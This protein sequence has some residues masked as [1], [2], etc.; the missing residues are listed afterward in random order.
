MS[1]DAQINTYLDNNI[2]DYL[3]LQEIAES[4]LNRQEADVDPNSDVKHL[5]YEDYKANNNSFYNLDGITINE[6]LVNEFKVAI[7]SYPTL[8]IAQQ[9]S[10]TPTDQSLNID[11][12]GGAGKYT[13]IPSEQANYFIQNYNILDYYGNDKSGFSAT[14]FQNKNTGEKIISFRSTEFGEDFIKDTSAD[15]EIGNFGL[16]VGQTISMVQYIEHLKQTGI[17]KTDDNIVATGYSLGSNLSSEFEKMYNSE[18]NIN[19][20]YNFNGPGA[21]SITNPIGMTGDPYINLKNEY[22]LYQNAVNQICNLATDPTNLSMNDANNIITQLNFTDSEKTR[23]TNFV[24]SMYLNKAVFP[25]V[26]ESNMNLVDL[27]NTIN[28]QST[29]NEVSKS[30]LI[31]LNEDGY[32]TIYK[33]NVTTNSYYNNIR[34]YIVQEFSAQKANIGNNSPGLSSGTFSL[35]SINSVLFSGIEGGKT[36]YQIDPS[37]YN[38]KATWIAGRSLQNAEDLMPSDYS[39]VSYS[40]YY[41]NPNDI[42]VEDRPDLEGNGTRLPISDLTKYLT[43]DFGNT[44]SITLLNKSLGLMSFL[45]KIEGA[46]NIDVAKYTSIIG[47]STSEKAAHWITNS[48]LQAGSFTELNYG[49]QNSIA[50]VMNRI[51]KAIVPNSNQPDILFDNTLGGWADVNKLNQLEKRKEEI[52]NTLK[53]QNTTISLVSLYQAQSS[54]FDLNS[55]PKIITSKDDIYTKVMQNDA[56]GQAY[57]YALE[58]LNPFVIKGLD[59]N[60]MPNFI[61]KNPTDESIEWYLNRIDILREIIKDNTNNNP[62][63]LATS[64]ISV[65]DKNQGLK[66]HTVFQEASKLIASNMS[67]L[68]Q[69]TNVPSEVANNNS[70]NYYGLHSSKFYVDG[71]FAYSPSYIIKDKLK[72]YDLDKEQAINNPIKDNLYYLNPLVSS[73]TSKVD[74][75]NE[76]IFMNF[77]KNAIFNALNGNSPAIPYLTNYAGSLTD[78][79]NFDVITKIDLKGGDDYIEIKNND[80]KAFIEGSSGKK[81]YYL[82]AKETV[83]DDKDKT[84]TI[85]LDGIK[86]TGGIYQDILTRV[87]TEVIDGITHTLTYKLDNNNQLTITHDNTG[88]KVIISN[89]SN[90][91]NGS[92]FGFNINEG[93][94]N[95]TVLGVNLESFLNNTIQKD[96]LQTT[97]SSS[98]T[99]ANAFMNDVTKNFSIAGNNAVRY[100]SGTDLVIYDRTNPTKMSVV[101][102]FYNAD[103]TI[104]TY[105]STVTRVVNADTGETAQDPVSSQINIV[106]ADEHVQDIPKTTVYHIDQLLF[107]LRNNMEIDYRGNEKY[108]LENPT[109]DNININKDGNDLVFT[110]N[111]PT[112][113]FNNGVYAEGKVT[114]KNYF[115]FDHSNSTNMLMYQNGVRT[116]LTPTDVN[117]KLSLR[118]SDGGVNY[119]ANATDPFHIIVGGMGDDNIKGT[120]RDEVFESLGGN[121]YN[122][123]SIQSSNDGNDVFTG[124]G[125]NDTFIFSGAFGS[126]R[127]TDFNSGDKIILFNSINGIPVNYQAIRSGDDL[128]LKSTNT[129]GVYNTQLKVDNYFVN[130]DY[131]NNSG[132][133]MKDPNLIYGTDS[134]GEVV[135]ATQSQQDYV[136]QTADLQKIDTLT[137]NNS[138]L[139]YSQTDPTVE[140]TPVDPSDPTKPRDSYH[141]PGTYHHI[142]G[143]ELDNTITITRNNT[144]VEGGEVKSLLN[145][146]NDTYI[147]NI[148]EN[149]PTIK[150]E[151]RTEIDFSLKGG[152]DVVKGGSYQEDGQYG[153]IVYLKGVNLSDVVF[154]KTEDNGTL[155]T[156]SATLTDGSTINL[157]INNSLTDN[158]VLFKTDNQL[159][160]LSDINNAIINNNTIVSGNDTGNTFDYSNSYKNY[161]IHGG[162][163]ADT[164]TGSNGNDIINAGKGND[165]IYLS[166]GHDTY[167]F[168]QGDGIDTFHFKDVREKFDSTF[169]LDNNYNPQDIQ[170]SYDPNN[171]KIYLNFSPTEGVVFT[172]SSWQD[173]AFLSDGLKLKFANGQDLTVPDQ[174]NIVNSMPFTIN[175]SQPTNIIN[176]TDNSDSLTTDTSNNNIVYGNGG[177][178]TIISNISD[179]KS[180]IIGGTGNDNITANDGSI[181][182]VKDG[183]GHDT[184][185]SDNSNYM[186]EMIHNAPRTIQTTQTLFDLN[187]QGNDLEINY[188]TDPNDVVVLKDYFTKTNNNVKL[189]VFD[190]QNNKTNLY[191]LEDIFSQLNLDQTKLV[192]LEGITI[193]PGDVTPVKQSDT[194]Q[195]IGGQITYQYLNGNKYQDQQGIDTIMNNINN[196]QLF[197]NKQ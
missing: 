143:N 164:I 161:E 116:E 57:R 6:K 36:G 142:V 1:V 175:P 155:K 72:Q 95:T 28:M 176:G 35:S 118:L 97:I 93:T 78:I 45:S 96:D 53:A 188:T 110:L 159:V 183:D 74:S 39:F 27:L 166:S 58:N 128:I 189:A 154:N 104:K 88:D 98:Y 168:N 127:I 75:D 41:T 162:A 19:K 107:T 76:K 179:K 129:S 135:S 22:I 139:N 109:G 192:N 190:D 21:G 50:M 102:D 8:K 60:N 10:K 178:D 117:N 29:E 137:L 38:N 56:E 151:F 147:I 33:N 48:S 177:D 156:I 7:G 197:A 163:G 130:V 25:N 133:V 68:E 193:K 173:F 180:F 157:E 165:D 115:A 153:D 61:A 108:L 49:D 152:S 11:Y 43:G 42:A 51:Y 34:D 24:D 149:L 160:K 106:G 40:N 77:D 14:V 12:E 111:N 120:S 85:T 23:I 169:V 80:T 4:K 90:W 79:N 194:G 123:G 47:A 105:N 112:Y 81:T 20:I 119:Q 125:G 187:V 170:Y 31:K 195:I 103:G 69:F 63:F 15:E 158:T 184:I 59:Y 99:D 26:I 66:F 167:I 124:G 16:P 141:S 138:E 30:D 100:Q 140:N 174:I 196:G 64:N 52:V 146:G 122:N 83:I 131:Q 145:D 144:V 186:I 62:N 91:G 94:I 5:F 65:D 55:P 101:K 92:S 17:I 18:F 54:D 86:L 32:N 9:E 134:N 113:E 150:N 82:N 185:S 37:F 172:D 121:I 71:T 70:I 87:Q 13:K 136:F 3:L 132:I 114:V 46:S 148:T 191:S 89:M 44:H 67:Q 182:V 73:F 84:G 126:D 2:T 171:Q 181:V